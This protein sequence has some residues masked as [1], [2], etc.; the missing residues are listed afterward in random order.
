MM[1]TSLCLEVS[2]LSFAVDVS[3]LI[4]G[5][6]EAFVGEGPDVKKLCKVTVD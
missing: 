4:R 5:V 2:D 1:I 6:L 3:R